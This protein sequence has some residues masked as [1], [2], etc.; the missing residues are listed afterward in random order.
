G[1]PAITLSYS[2]KYEGVIGTMIGR[3][4][5]IL[6][7]ND[8]AL[9]ADGTIVSNILAKASDVLARHPSLC[10]QVQEA[11]SQQ[12]LMAASSLDLTAALVRTAAATGES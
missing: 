3:A 4:D 6:E 12:K 8:P 7:G 11:V 9:W 1:K 2:K 10:S 5:L